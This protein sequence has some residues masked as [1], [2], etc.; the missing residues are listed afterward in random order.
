MTSPILPLRGAARSV[1]PK[2]LSVGAAIMLFGCGN[3]LSES[4]VQNAYFRWS[5]NFQ[6]KFNR[7]SDSER[8][9]LRDQSKQFRVNECKKWT[10]RPFVYIFEP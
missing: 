7:V 10:D 5:L 4:A 3:G 2:L 6:S 1:L 8:D 9:T